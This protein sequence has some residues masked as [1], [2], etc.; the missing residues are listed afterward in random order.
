MQT[1]RVLDFSKGYTKLIWQ[2][3]LLRYTKLTMYLANLFGKICKAYL[4]YRSKRYIKLIWYI[5]KQNSELCKSPFWTRTFFPDK[6]H[7]VWF[8][9]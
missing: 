3:Y 2:A 8:V 1:S 9:R 6:I 5:P 7:F 4:V